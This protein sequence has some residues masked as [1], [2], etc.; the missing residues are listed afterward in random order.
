MGHLRRVAS[1]HD[2]NRRSAANGRILDL[3]AMCRSEPLREPLHGM[4]NGPPN[5]AIVLRVFGRRRSDP[6][7]DRHQ[8][9][10]HAATR[11]AGP[12]SGSR[13]CLQGIQAVGMEMRLQ[14][15]KRQSAAV[16]IGTQVV[17]R[18]LG[19]DVESLR[20]DFGGVCASAIRGVSVALRLSAAGSSSLVMSRLDSAVSC[21]FPR[22]P[23]PSDQP[24]KA[25]APRARRAT[26]TAIPVVVATTSPV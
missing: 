19:D 10:N 25:N 15:P 6:E 12:A 16:R 20:L 9:T 1:P 18:R 26:T 8:C 13:Q 5:L 22:C 24:N 2:S 4:D 3:L 17:E 11:F 23:P 14:R 7:P 21:R